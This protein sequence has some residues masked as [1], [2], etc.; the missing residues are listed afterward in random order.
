MPKIISAIIFCFLSGRSQEE[1]R[2]ATSRITGPMCKTINWKENQNVT[3]N[4]MIPK[5]WKPITQLCKYRKLVDISNFNPRITFLHESLELTRSNEGFD[6]EASKEEV[7]L[8]F[9]LRSIQSRSCLSVTCSIR[10]VSVLF[11]WQ[12]P[13]V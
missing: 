1:N 13:M 3:K 11:L 12:L 7:Y 10:S 6:M 9:H 5:I 8:G 2:R 4:N